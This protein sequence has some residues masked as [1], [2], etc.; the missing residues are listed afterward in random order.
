M[1]LAFID[2]HTHIYLEEFDADRAEVV[3]RARQAGAVKLLLPNID[4]ASVRPMLKLCADYP[5]VCFPML[6]LHPTELPP[7][8]RPVLDEMERALAAD[9]RYV[10]V[11]E[12]GLD[13]YWDDSRREEQIEVFR[14]QVEWAVG[15]GLPLM[16][17]SRSAHRE[18]VETLAPYAGRLSGGVFHCFGGTADEAR[19]LLAFPGFALGIGGVVTFRKSE[20]PSSL[21]CVPLDRLVLETDAPYLAPVPCRGR[22]NE[23]AFIPY[24]IKRL[25]EV[26]A[27]TPEEVAARTTATA[28]SLFFS[29]RR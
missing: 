27:V 3:G 18:L 22:R 4:A 17:H 13:F 6:G 9:R 5:D 12:V 10:A 7:E 1:S 21:A 26:Y 8:P 11:G 28:E 20:L 25:A 2:T 24:I 23:P 16:I 15:F 29:R 14:R 19:E